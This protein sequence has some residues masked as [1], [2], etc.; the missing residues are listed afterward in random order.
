MHLRSDR[1]CAKS[2]NSHAARQSVRAIHEVVQIRNPADTKQQRDDKQGF[3][4]G[5][6]QP[7]R[8]RRRRQVS[9]QPPKARLLMPPPFIQRRPLPKGIS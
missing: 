7:Q 2:S 4:A 8:K 6:D 1:E 9:R 5:M 3:R